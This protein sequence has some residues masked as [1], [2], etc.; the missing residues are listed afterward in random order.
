MPE[1]L[2][3]DESTFKSLRDFI[4]EK[5]GIY[6]SDQ[7]KYLMETKISE[8]IKDKNFKDFGEYAYF[9]MYSKDYKD[10]LKYLFNAITINETSFFRNMPQIESFSS[11]ILPE[12]V[13]L[14]DRAG[15]KTINLMSAG[16]STGEEPYTLAIICSEFVEKHAPGWRFVIEAGDLSESAL[17]QAR[18]GVY[19]EY[20]LRN[21]PPKLLEKYFTK[22]GDNY[23]VNDSLKRMIRFFPLNLMDDNRMRRITKKD[24]VFC[25]NV[26]IYFDL[27]VK[28]KVVNYFYDMLKLSGYLVIGHSESLHSIT[29]AFKIVHFPGALA[30]KK[31]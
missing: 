17:M 26:M 1:T 24:V 15:F 25:R 8:R 18:D 2:Q 12:L 6:F 13:K 30:Y 16:C 4:Y 28:K 11:S 3:M 5:S 27:S 7:K 10:E 9:L 20:T 29:R 19:S 23:V 31:E 21:V 22:D 14:P